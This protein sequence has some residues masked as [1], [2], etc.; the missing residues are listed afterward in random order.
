MSTKWAKTY[1]VPNWTT[2][3]VKKKVCPEKTNF[4]GR[5]SGQKNE[6][7]FSAQP[8]W[9]TFS[10]FKSWTRFFLVS[11]QNRKSVQTFFDRISLNTYFFWSKSCYSSSLRQYQLRKQKKSLFSA[12]LLTVNFWLFPFLPR[13]SAQNSCFE[14]LS[15]TSAQKVCSAPFFWTNFFLDQKRCSVWHTICFC[16]FFVF[17]FS[18]PKYL[19][20]KTIQLD[21][22]EDLPP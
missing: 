9:T 10:G 5:N 1:C 12:F 11:V 13:T 14:N 4:L 20:K 7:L 3:L 16:P 6:N 17:W 2:F 19:P 15:K 8:F 18:C 22:P 21:S